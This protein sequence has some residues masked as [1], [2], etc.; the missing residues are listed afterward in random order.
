MTVPVAALGRPGP[1]EPSPPPLDVLLHQ[2]I[3]HSPGAV[4][5]RC[6]DESVSYAELDA[7]AAR[8]AHRLRDLGAGPERVVGLCLP[9][10]VDL[11]VAVLAVLKAGAAYL[12]L[13]PAAPSAR[14]AELLDEANTSF[15]VTTPAL[16]TGIGPGRPVLTLDPADARDR[17]ASRVESYA[18][19]DNLA[20]VIYTSGSTGRPKPVGVTHRSLVN[21]AQ[22]LRE[23]CDLTGTDR[24]LQ[25]A[26]LTFDAA[27]EEIFPTWLAGAALVLLT[28]PVP[29]THVVERLVRDHQVSVVNLPTAY[30]HQWADELITQGRSLPAGVRLIVIGGEAASAAVLSRW[31]RHTGVPILNTYGVT[32]A[33]ISNLAT[34]PGPSTPETTVS[35]GRP[36]GG[37]TAH[38]V[39]TDGRRVPAGAPGELL[40]GGVG[41]AR[42]YLNRPALTAE[43]FVPDP[44]GGRPGARLY[45]S[46]DLA[47]QRPDGELDFLG[48][49]DDQVKIRGQ[50]VEPGE[51]AAAVATHPG[52]RSAY[53]AV[54]EAPAGGAQLIAYVVA[55]DPATGVTE[56][57]LRRH[58][59]DRLPTAMIPAGWCLVDALPLTAHGKVDRAQLPDPVAGPATAGQAPTTAVE[60]AL[61]TI[62]GDLLERGGVGPDDDFFD[63]GGHSLLAIA[64]MSRIASTF[65]LAVPVAVLF[66]YPKLADLAAVIADSLDELPETDA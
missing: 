24:V 27:A 40:I 57:D 38:L 51:V 19:I 50:R 21:H 5:I 45:R 42:G 13:D 59:A 53:V 36:I 26:S 18:D 10:G 14:R 28:D 17:P 58:V 37:T 60:R 3:D 11:I 47:R 6:D 66:D 15:V 46:G 54:R 52:V 44:F 43:R 9:R 63:L 41:L 22:R 2:R 29:A 64:M 56:P 62:W 35:L 1:A 65:D 30:W 23:L 55:A 33:T 12:P 16:S 48:R 31:Q 34:R 25:F 32:E 4:A 20:Y 49:L 61:A 8:L 39:G 7:R